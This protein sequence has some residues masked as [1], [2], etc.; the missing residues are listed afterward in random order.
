MREEEKYEI[1][2]Y[3]KHEQ[4]VHGVTIMDGRITYC[5]NIDSK[6]VT[7][8]RSLSKII[9]DSIKETIKQGYDSK[10]RER[11]RILK[12]KGVRL[13]YV[14]DNFRGA[15]IYS[16]VGGDWPENTKQIRVVGG[17]YIGAVEKHT[18]TVIAHQRGATIVYEHP[19]NCTYEEVQTFR[20]SDKFCYL[21]RSGD[22]LKTDDYTY[23]VLSVNFAKQALLVK[24]D[25]MLSQMYHDAIIPVHEYEYITNME[26][27]DGCDADF[28]I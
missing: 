5:S 13:E 26:D 3:L 16:P 17:I 28:E 4:R 7:I 11:F 23:R 15:E 21:L 12:E 19:D 2:A 27:V 6:H 25:S 10:L 8:D 18:D 24:N 1:M 20:E 9:I 14:S 22:L